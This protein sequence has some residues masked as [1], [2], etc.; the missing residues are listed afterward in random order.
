MYSTT[1]SLRKDVM[2]PE[3]TS[4]ALPVWNRLGNRPKWLA[5][6]VTMRGIVLCDSALDLMGMAMQNLFATFRKVIV[7]LLLR[8]DGGDTGPTVTLDIASPGTYSLGGWALQVV[9]ADIPSAHPVQVMYGLFFRMSGVRAD[10]I[11]A[12][13]IWRRRSSGAW[14]SVSCQVYRAYEDSWCVIFPE[15][16]A[17]ALFEARVG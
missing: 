1:W 13:A 12:L 10:K 17:A 4:L 3:L 16:E 11:A 14:L 7:S 2:M 9:V 8:H 15:N 5:M 6:H